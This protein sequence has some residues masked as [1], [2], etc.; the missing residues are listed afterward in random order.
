MANI[1][2]IQISKPDLRSLSNTWPLEQIFTNDISVAATKKVGLSGTGGDTYWYEKSADVAALVV[3]G[4]EAVTFTESTTV[5]AAFSGPISATT[6]TF[7]SSV[8]Q[9]DTWGIAGSVG[10]I[11][12][13]RQY[14]RNDSDTGAA[15]MGLWSLVKVD[16][17]NDQ[18]WTNPDAGLRGIFSDIETEAGSTGTLTKV[19]GFYAYTNIAD[20]ATITDLVGLYIDT[21]IV[22]G[23]K[24][25][26]E[27]GIYIKNQNTGATLNY[28]I[29]VE[30]GAS[31][32]GGG[33]QSTTAKC[34]SNVG[35]VN[36]GVTA[37]EYGDGYNHVTVLTVSQVDALTLADNA[38]LADGYLLYTLPAGAICVDY[39]YMSM[40][41]TAAE[42]TTATA[43]V[44]LGTTLASAAQAT[45]DLDNAACENI[46]T[47]QTAANCSGTATVKTAAPTAGI[48]YIIESADDHT[49]YFN[50]ADTWADTAGV[51]LTADIAGTVVIAWRFLA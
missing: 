2:S 35:A 46:I 41:V 42:D 12:I 23:G 28:A 31:Y 13:S 36:T 22:A 6:G 14:Y 50:V 25:T 19:T 33:V 4:V 51:D 29:Y 32:F 5:T 27:Y 18:N 26:N 7:T 16:A 39:S 11:N 21:P 9:S 20:A 34:T 38:A 30:G 24:V 45:L 15:G 37:V 47:G 10:A 1:G 44:G 40:A 3:G 17:A 8:S 49:I 43:D 48:P